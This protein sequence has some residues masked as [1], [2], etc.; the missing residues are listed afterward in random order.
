MGLL[1]L[2]LFILLIPLTVTVRLDDT[3]NTSVCLRI[4]GIRFFRT[5]KP[6]KPV[7][8]RDYTPR[9]MKRR[10]RKQAKKE[11]KKAAKK[12]PKIAE[13]HSQAPGT[14]AS[15]SD[16]LSFVTGLAKTIL[17]RTLSH[18]RV[19]VY[20]LAVTVASSDAAKTALLYGAI[21]SAVAFLLETLEQFSNLKIASGAPVGVQA[22]F[23]EDKCHVDL[24]VRFH[25]R[26]IHLI[27]VAIRAMLQ[28][29]RSPRSKKHHS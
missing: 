8:L 18:A 9:A 6:E 11:A 24:H 26:V 27:D 13:A 29:V 28:A 20:R 25:L 23:T 7:R 21:S 15:L 14:E 3:G 22:D 12:K 19:K 1:A 16:K 17:G 5:P 10:A 4:L 2:I